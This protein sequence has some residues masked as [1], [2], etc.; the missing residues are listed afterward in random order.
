MRGA[1]PGVCK[2]EHCTSECRRNPILNGVRGA[3]PA[4]VSYD[5]PMHAMTTRCVCRR[6]HTNACA[7][8]ATRKPR[9]R[10]KDLSRAFIGARHPETHSSSG[11]QQRL[12]AIQARKRHGQC[13]SPSTWYICGSPVMRIVCWRPSPFQTRPSPPFA[14]SPRIH[15][16]GFP[17][18]PLSTESTLQSH[19]THPPCHSPRVS[20]PLARGGV[21]PAGAKPRPRPIQPP[22]GLLVYV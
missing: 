15:P 19:S 10:C 18:A 21:D 6:I 5:K 8:H 3:A 16:A 20:P 13:P 14:P 12:P 9:E 11:Q 2:S 22:F 4:I 7:G 1:V 17:R